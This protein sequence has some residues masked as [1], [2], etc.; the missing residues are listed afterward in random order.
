MNT[1]SIL[2][3]PRLTPAAK[4]AW[5]YMQEQQQDGSYTGSYPQL[6]RG[7]GVHENTV[8]ELMRQLEMAGLVTRE[9]RGSYTTAIHLHT[10][11]GR[12]VT[13]ESRSA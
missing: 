12:S 13:R 4:C 1:L 10:L 8:F 9:R 5:F 11:P 3:H 2:R 6:A 7:I